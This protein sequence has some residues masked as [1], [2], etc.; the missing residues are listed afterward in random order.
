MTHHFGNRRRYFAAPLI[1]VALAGFGALTMLLWNALLPI[2]FHLPVITFWQAVGL[3]I[4]ARLIFGFSPPWHH[5]HGHNHCKKSH[6]REKW[7]GM[8]PEQRDEFMKH[9]HCRPWWAKSKMD[10]VINQDVSE[11]K[12]V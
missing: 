11:N 3:L 2:I 12:S 6:F 7:E 8:S 1:L 5:G 4:L 10:D 9:Y